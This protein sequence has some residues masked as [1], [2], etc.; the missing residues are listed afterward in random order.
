[1]S[2]RYLSCAEVAEVI[3]VKPNTLSRYNLPDPDA[4][5]GKTRGWLPETIEVWHSQRPSQRADGG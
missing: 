1:M 4:W 2:V 5:I 3:G